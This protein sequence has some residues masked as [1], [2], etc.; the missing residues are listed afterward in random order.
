[1]SSNSNVVDFDSAKEARKPPPRTLD[2]HVIETRVALVVCG[3]TVPLSPA[4]AR[5]LGEMLLRGAD[6]AEQAEQEAREEL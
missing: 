2:A 4:A 6:Q 1:M 5:S 3:I